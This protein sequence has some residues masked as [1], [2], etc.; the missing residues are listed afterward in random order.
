MDLV[1]KVVEDAA[2]KVH[3][4]VVP[5]GTKRI[6]VLHSTVWAVRR[7]GPC[8]VGRPVTCSTEESGGDWLCLWMGGGESRDAC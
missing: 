4:I 3:P 2:V 1:A 6:A 7:V 5:E 8:T